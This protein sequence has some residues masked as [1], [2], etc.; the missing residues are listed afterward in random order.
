MRIEVDA[1]YPKEREEHLR[2]MMTKDQEDEKKDFTSEE[3][4]RSQRELD[5]QVT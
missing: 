4:W 5:L 1:S 3:I 2:Y